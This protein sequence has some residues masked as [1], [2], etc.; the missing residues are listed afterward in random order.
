[1]KH[2]KRILSIIC[3]CCI[4]SAQTNVATTA[5][6]FLEIGAGARSLALGGAF[7]SLANDVSALYW[8]PAGI[9]NISRPSVQFFH[10]PWLVDTEYFY[11]G[12]VVPIGPSDALG[13]TYTAV[14]MDEMMV[15]T[16]QSPEGTG[17]K[18]DASSLAMGVAYSKR[19]T[20]R[21]SFGIQFKFVQEKIWQMHAKALSVDIGTLFITE[22]GT[23]IGMSISNFGDKMGMDG[24][25]TA[26]DA[27]IDETIY[28]NN[29]RIDAHLDA[30][31]W[32]LPLLFRF[33]VSRDLIFSGGHRF[34]VSTDATHP[35]NNVEY[36][37]TGAEYTFKDLISLRI[38][39][40]DMF[41]NDAEQGLSYGAGMNYQI[42][43]G[44]LVRLDY[45][46]RPFGVFQTV[47]GYSI[48]ITF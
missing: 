26:I 33:G 42:P 8:N 23:R 40:S 25:N 35:N 19:L 2:L 20:D 1:M 10:S 11:S 41:N 5:A 3:F 32:P 36:V 12:M 21:F 7:V 16:V 46:F 22:K 38:G 24:I 14:V 39:R 31:K 45:V 17:E 34:T 27:D 30:A 18:F 15:R 37:N 13:F 29:D 4:L 43:R 48:D 28:G 44:P 9:V 47:T 6:S